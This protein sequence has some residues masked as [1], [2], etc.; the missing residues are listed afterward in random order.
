MNKPLIL[1]LTTV[2]HGDLPDVGGKAAL[3]GELLAAGFPVPAGLCITTTAFQLALAAHQ[4]PIQAILQQPDLQQPNVAAVA[5]AAIA[6][7]L[8][9]LALPAL[10]LEELQTQLPQLAEPTTLLAVR[11]SATA[12][13]QVDASYAGQYESVLG[14]KGVDAVVAAILTCWHSF[15]SANALVA[16][17]AHAA[18]G[19][20]EGMAVLIQPI[21]AADCAGVAFSVDPVQ[22]RRDRAVINA[23]WGLGVGVVDGTVATDTL[24]VQ[25]TNFQVE[26]QE[27]SEK[28]EQ[29]ALNEVGAL[30]RVAITDER[31]RAACLP[32]AWAERV[33]QFVVAAEVLC[34]RPQEM[35]WAIADNQLWVL[36]SR[37][38]TGLPASWSPSS[39]FPV[40][41]ENKEDPHTLWRLWHERET[42]A[43]LLPLEQD[44][45]VQLESTWEDACR[46]LGVE[47]K[48][49]FKY[50]N[51]RAYTRPVPINWTAADRHIRRTAMEDLRNRLHEQGLTTWDHWGPEIVKATERLRAFAHDTADGP[52]LAD[53]LEEALAVR[54]RHYIHHPMM[55]FKPPQA[56]FAAYA[57]V[58]GIPVE[59]AETAAYHLLDADETP[60][61]DLT[62]RLYALAQTAQQHPAL[63]ALLTRQPPDLLQ[64]VTALPQGQE[65]LAQL[66]AL[67]DIYGERTG[68]GWGSETTLRVPTWREEPMAVLRLL[69]PFL[70]SDV[71]A[72]TVVRQRAQ[73]TRDTEVAT[74]CAACTD[75]AAVVEFRRQLTYA[76][77][78]H[79]VLEIHNHYIDQLSMGQLRQAVM[80]AAQ[81]FVKQGKLTTATNVLWLYFDEILTAL[82]DP[83]AAPFAA[84]I[85]ARHV[86]H[87][88]WTQMSA[89]TILGAPAHRLPERPSLQDEVNTAA[90]GETGQL[91]G[92]GAS[93]GQRQGR[94]Q[95]MH[96]PLSLPT[97]APGD[98]LVA[99]NVGPLWT[100]VFSILGGLVLE[101]GSVGQH[102]AA[103]AREYGVPTVIQ[104]K[105]ARH[106]IPDGA[107]ILVNGSQG[108]VT[109]LA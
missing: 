29:M 5:A 69:P 78:V 41:W 55:V 105:Q 64:Q 66:A 79:A 80:A 8:V 93:P 96:D 57:A 54:R 109:I 37:P 88:R 7:R 83:T 49:L 18:L 106:R 98:I 2:R 1:S 84:T 100:P 77:K 10:L 60:L 75:T 101:S 4:A 63:A 23:A 46:I 103:T 90:T 56:F 47:R 39:P 67:L 3:L 27:I 26:F 21:I 87:H 68:D 70:R 17:A 44:H 35:E 50:C 72:P 6:K 42:P 104:V 73:Q 13:D 62:D 86:E 34:E 45:L 30:I 107:W 95:I 32:P 108:Q 40:T 92:L 20:Q 24:W 33:A 51:G 38:L 71:E 22:Q 76:R 11:S 61:T 74:L 43:V 91:S 48:L 53:H 25:R 85:A 82:R 19:I 102:A 28:P 16:R 65:F 89:P 31:R 99:E 14:V 94:A 9:D 81:W 52:A 15:F 58:A 12:E 36:Q 97:L 59:A